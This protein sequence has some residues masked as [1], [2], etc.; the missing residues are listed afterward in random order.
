MKFLQGTLF[1]LAFLTLFAACKDDETPGGTDACTS[2]FNQSALFTNVADNLILP[3][4]RDFD[5]KLADLKS[6]H[7]TFAAAPTN[8]N[9]TVLRS[10]LET[11]WISWQS[12]AQYSFGPAESV[13]LRNSVNNFPLDL[14]MTQTRVADKTYEFGNP[15]DYT[16]GFPALDYFFFGIN[17]SKENVL[18][19][20]QNDDTAELYLDYGR[21]LL[22]DLK[23]KSTYV[24]STW[25]S[26]YRTTFINNTGTAA[27]TSLSLIINSLNQNYEMIKREKLGVPVGVLT[28]GFANPDRVEAPYAGISARLT[29]EAVTAAYNYYRGYGADIDGLGLDDFLREIDAQKEGQSLAALIDAQFKS[30]IESI[31][32]LTD[33]LAAQIEDDN[34][35][36]E[37]AYIEVTKNVVNLKTDMPSVL[38]VSITYID[39]PSDSD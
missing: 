24:L 28:L 19:F 10:A 11:A 31:D 13:F 21:E 27:G 9:L 16:Y 25:E 34:E 4:L 30:A 37:A 1:A 22:F 7:E 2:D 14:E 12:A 38:C 6:T 20:Y 32:R 17:G 5:T 8:E 36:V 26:D 39:N 15:E 33:P 29:R 35:T 18:D 3:A 23:T